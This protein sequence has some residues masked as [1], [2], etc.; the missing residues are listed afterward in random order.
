MN[1]KKQ[2]IKLCSMLLFMLPIYVSAFEIAG[3]QGIVSN[4]THDK[5]S[6]LRG[7]FISW[8]KNSKRLVASIGEFSLSSSSVVD[9]RRVKEQ[10]KSHVSIKFNGDKIIEVIIY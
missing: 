6:T 7:E 4:N 9:D 8:E 5:A 1:T 2:G 3:D 10:Q